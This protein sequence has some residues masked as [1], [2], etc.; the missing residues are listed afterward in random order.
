MNWSSD[1]LGTPLGGAIILGRLDGIP[2]LVEVAD[3]IVVDS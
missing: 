2:L 1:T 3:A